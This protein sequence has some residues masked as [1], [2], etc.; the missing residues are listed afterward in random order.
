MA[1]GRFNGQAQDDLG[2]ATTAEISVFTESTGALAAIFSD[3]D[4][5]TPKANPFDA[6]ADGYFF[7]HAAGGAYRIDADLDGD[8][9]TWRYVAIG[10]G[11]ES[12]AAAGTTRTVTAAGDATVG[13]GDL[14]LVIKKT[15]GAATNVN[16][17]AAAARNGVD[18]MIK[19]GKG[20]ADVNPITPRFSG[21]EDCDGIS[22]GES[23]GLE[24]RSPYGFLWMRPL[25][26]GSGY[27]LMPSNL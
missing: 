4:G 15:V 18:V 9:R 7:F 6:D 3:R 5:V 10:T 21:S 8:V 26:D 25:P 14:C 13:A 12:D 11:G 23:P 17:P 22:N 27:F 2:N 20:D 1:L 16:I 24:I 19:D